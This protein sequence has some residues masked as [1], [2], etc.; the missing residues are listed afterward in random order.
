MKTQSSTEEPLFALF[1]KGSF[2]Y[3][4][5]T[6]DASS[7]AEFDRS[8]AFIVNENRSDVSLKLVLSYKFIREEFF[9]S[10]RMK[11]WISSSSKE[12]GFR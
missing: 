11:I 8:F 3:L 1:D 9:Y 10:S 12:G 5:A 4:V 7:P 6:R 2:F